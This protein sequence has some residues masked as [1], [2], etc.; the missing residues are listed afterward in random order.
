MGEILA[1]YMDDR[2][3]H[4]A[5]PERLA[6]AAKALAPFWADQ[7]ASAVKGT[8]CR[9]YV[10]SRGVADS[11]AR[12]ELGALQAALN[13]AHAEGLLVH[14]LK[15]TL[16]AKGAAR[17]RWLTEEEAGRLIDAAAPHLRRFILI[18]LYTG[19][20]KQAI[21]GL[22][23][24]PATDAGWVDMERG[25]ISF[26]GQRQAETA[27]RKGRVKIPAPLLDHLHEWQDG[28][29]HVIH[30]RGSPVASIKRAWSEAVRRAGLNDVRPHDLKRTA[31]TWAFQDGMTKE[32]AADWFE[33]TTATLESVYRAHS[34]EHQGRALSIVGRRTVA[35]NVARD[36]GGRG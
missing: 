33:T 22:R 4:V 8:V 24:M 28:A 11:T 9:A 32:D 29:S 14:P 18:A 31:V 19:R 25:F 36:D 5:D 12:R 35:R 23:W 2:G 34:P 30:H 20:R 10:K 26:I 15:V 21:L 27:K 17:D 3:P 1:R 7:K 16:P 13:H 6:N